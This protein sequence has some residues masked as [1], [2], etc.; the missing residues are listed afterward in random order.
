MLA[1][2]LSKII[3]TIKKRLLTKDFGCNDSSHRKF[4]YIRSETKY[5]I[6]THAATCGSKLPM[7]P[8]YLR[9]PVL[10]KAPACIGRSM[11][12]IRVENKKTI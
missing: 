10:Y 9:L 1:T 2:L 11:A 12:M 4:F 3:F 5:K 8:L 6:A 7:A